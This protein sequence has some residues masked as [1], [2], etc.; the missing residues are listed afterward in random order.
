MSKKKRNNFYSNLIKK[1]KKIIK[2]DKKY[3]KNNFTSIIIKLIFIS[4]VLF[5][6]YY[7]NSNYSNNISLLAVNEADNGNIQ[8]GS[9]INLN[10][11]IKPGTGNIFINLGTI[12]DID[13]QIS[14][15][16][17]Q[18]IACDIFNLDCSSYDFY[19]SFNGNAIVLKGP[20][21]SSAI[22]ILV[23][24][25]MQFEKLNNN[26]V[27]T[28]ALNSGGIIGN[29]GGVSEKIKVAELKGYKKVIIPTFSKYSKLNNSKIEV[30]KAMDLVN[31][32]NLFTN[33]NFKI[34]TF[35]INKTKYE[36]LMK[37]LA[38]NLC[39]RSIN[40]SNQINT[41]K[42][43]NN[44][45]LKIYLTQSQKSYNSSQIAIKN[46]N[47]YSAGS[48]CYNSNLNSRL[49]I[50]NLEN[51]SN[52]NLQNKINKFENKVNLKLVNISSE[53]YRKKIITINDFYVYLL[54]NNRIDEAKNYFEQINKLNLKLNDF[55][56]SENN[57]LI[58]N[59]S[60]QTLINSSNNTL[61]NKTNLKNITLIKN[62]EQN[63]ITQKK[64]LYSFAYERFY[65]VKL[66]ERFIENYGTK[67]N[68]DDQKIKNV[69]LNINREI[70]IKQELLK[71]YNINY[72]DEQVNKQSV[73]NNEFTNQYLC[74]YN[75]LELNGKMNTILNGAGIENNNTVQ[76]AKDLQ[77]FTAS[78]L[79]LNS[80]GEFPLI[81]YIYSQYSTE[82]LSQ[83]DSSAAMLYSNYA[84][85][86]L[87][88]N[89]Y[90]KDKNIKKS[91]FTN[92]LKESFNNLTFF[93]ALLI[94]IGFI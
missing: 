50:E 9:I 76:Y 30:K 44:S 93:G 89:L 28:G 80:N 74:I 70:S 10:L 82:L 83:N 78:R 57:K 24:K 4:F 11:Q 72:L 48:F 56:K 49:I 71:K 38:E 51:I 14:I 13:T 5:S 19:Y 40:L 53:E 45:S 94:I 8:G 43:K 69:C 58:I 17:S 60:N 31:A 42:I 47:Y 66:W 87:D 15:I 81:P 12:E 79:S 90:L 16:N 29:V 52:E 39:Q 36:K 20:S 73:Y 88:L 32:Y 18:K 55:I 65:T 26:T 63:I 86:Y 23:A 41:S 33:D 75:G 64:Q 22:A 35:P 68:F 3:I 54:L 1:S 46:K 7:I 84:L 85:S 25:T 61:E 37:S 77:E 92:T 91:L 67:I 59:I 34:K 2:E 62:Y 27:I 21:A 6:L